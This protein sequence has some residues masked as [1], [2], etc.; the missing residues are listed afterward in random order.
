VTGEVLVDALNVRAGPGTQ[1]EVVGK[2]SEGETFT[3]AGVS[4]DGTWGVLVG[5]QAR[6]VS[7]EYVQLDSELGALDDRPALDPGHGVAGKVD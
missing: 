2:L 4:A 3:L 5:R 6:W 1:C 7:L